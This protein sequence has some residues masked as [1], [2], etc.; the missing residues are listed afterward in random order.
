[1]TVQVTEKMRKQA[2]DNIALKPIELLFPGTAQS[3]QEGLCPI[4]KGEV[5]SFRNE[6]SAQE[7]RISGMCQK[8]QDA[9]FGGQ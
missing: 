7:Y 2:A 3:I 9:V 4:C 8:C 5:T 6:L 1:M